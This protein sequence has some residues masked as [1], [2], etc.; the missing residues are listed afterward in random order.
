MWLFTTLLVAEHA[1]TTAVVTSANSADDGHWPTIVTREN[2][3]TTLT[4]A[5]ATTGMASTDLLQ[6]FVEDPQGD[7][8]IRPYAFGTDAIERM[9]VSLP[10]SMIDADFEYGLQP[11]KWAGYGTVKGYPSVYQNEGIDIN[12][13]AVTTNYNSGSATNSLITVTFESAHGLSVGRCC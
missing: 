9:R 1:G 6:I 2:G 8:T 12:T 7:T 5:K 4:L 3:F 11:T 10:E 13:T